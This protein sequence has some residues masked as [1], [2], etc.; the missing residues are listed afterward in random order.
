[1]KA[2]I[3]AALSL[4]LALAAADAAQAHA[5]LLSAA[6]PINGLAKAP[7]QNLD[8]TFSEEISGKLSGVVVKGADG[9]P[10]PLATMTEDDGK[11]LMVML[12]QPLKPGVYS[13]GWRAVASDDGHR[14][15]G[16]YTVTVQ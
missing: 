7:L 1:M 4:L 2:R 9:R 3:C 10:I 15:E 8:L 13:I 5:K 14:T 16:T 11:G 6:P 12:K